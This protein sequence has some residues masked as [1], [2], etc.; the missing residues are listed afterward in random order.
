MDVF[1]P[2]DYDARELRSLADTE[3]PNT[4]IDPESGV[5]LPPVEG[6]GYRAP[7]PDEPSREQCER[8]VAIGG[9]DPSALGERPYL[10]TFP[11]APEARRVGR[12]WIAY[13]VR[14]AGETGTRNAISRYRALGWLGEDAATTLDARIDDA[15]AALVPGGGSLDRADHLLSFAH[16]IRLLG[17]ATA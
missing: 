10:G 12:D 16:V 1:D 13:L 17:V 3:D 4:D 9:V 15:V 7:A 8:L 2:G 14:T 5:T 6:S 11:D